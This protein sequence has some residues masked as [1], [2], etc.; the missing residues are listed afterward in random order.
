MNNDW[1]KQETFEQDAA[2]DDMSLDALSGP[3]FEDLSPPK[4]NGVSGM[5]V[6][7]LAVLVGGGVL[8]AMRMAGTGDPVASSGSAAEEKIEAALARLGGGEAGN[9]SGAATRHALDAL[10]RDTDDIIAMFA[11][12]PTRNQVGLEELQKNPFRLMLPR[13]EPRAGEPDQPQEPVDEAARQRE[14]RMQQLRREHGNLR[15]QSVLTGNPS[16]AVIGGEVLKVGDRIGSFEIVA[17]GSRE[18]RLKAED[19][20]FTLSL[21]APTDGRATN[22]R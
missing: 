22:R 21:S 6:L 16:L 11:D 1:D 9:D 18:V 8:W 14:Q 20:T 3:G 19:E 7:L 5:M 13:R 10:F 15:L 2:G 12:D 4:K 17:I